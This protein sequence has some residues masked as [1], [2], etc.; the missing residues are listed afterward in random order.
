MDSLAGFK[1]EI[2]HMPV[3]G[4]RRNFGGAHIS[5][6]A[7]HTLG[8]ITFLSAIT[9]NNMTNLSAAECLQ[10]PE[11]ARLPTTSPQEQGR[12]PTAPRGRGAKPTP[13]MFAS[14]TSS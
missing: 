6:I 12:V 8:P 11:E 1:W 7:P 4:F 2:A 5:D 10:A 3:L 14:E 13:S 9:H